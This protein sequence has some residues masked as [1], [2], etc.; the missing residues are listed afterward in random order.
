LRQTAPPSRTLHGFVPYRSKPKELFCAG[1]AEGGRV[2][3]DERGVIH[4][5]GARNF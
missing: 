1:H 3:T 5:P 2:Y 4:S